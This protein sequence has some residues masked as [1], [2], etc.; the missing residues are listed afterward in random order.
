MFKN[1]KKKS[2][3]S[4]HYCAEFPESKKNISV[5]EQLAGAVEHPSRVSRKGKSAATENNPNS[6]VDSVG[7]I[8]GR[9]LGNRE[10]KSTSILKLR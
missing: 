9:E 1:N 8:P 7:G 3:M 10:F 2:A 6:L 5:H 4:T